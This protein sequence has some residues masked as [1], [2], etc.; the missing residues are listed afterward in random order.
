M[1]TT[2]SADE[3][4][5][6]LVA[7]AKATGR[8]NVQAAVH[9]LTFTA[10]P[11]R[12]AFAELVEVEDV[13]WADGPVLAAFVKDWKVLPGSKAADRLGGGDQR[14]LALAVSLAGAESVDL[15]VNLAVGGYAYARRVIEAMA[16]ATGYSEHYEIKPTAKLDQL[17]AERDALLGS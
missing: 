4:S 6:M 11:H 12:Q 9:L 15:S 10:L 5:Q 1:S 8:T 7:G 14:L 16:I 13:G 2:Y 17:I 3:M